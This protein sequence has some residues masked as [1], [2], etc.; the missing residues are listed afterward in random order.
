VSSLRGSLQYAGI[1]LAAES[2]KVT[3]KKRPTKSEKEYWPRLQS[4]WLETASRVV[5]GALDLD[6]GW[7]DWLKF[8]EENGGPTLTEKVNAL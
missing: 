2:V 1:A 7:E 4:R 3:Q 8:W 5:A 6:Q